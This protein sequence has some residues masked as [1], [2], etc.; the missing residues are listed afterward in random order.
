MK[1]KADRLRI[2][3]RPHFK[4]HQSLEVGRWHKEVGISKITVSSVDMALFF[5]ADWDDITIAFPVNLREKETI[6]VLCRRVRQLNLLVESAEVVH[7]LAKGLTGSVRLFVKIDTGYHRTGVAFQD[8]AM[9]RTILQAI[10]EYENV[11]FAG[12]LVHAGHTYDVTGKDAV[13]HI[14]T[15]AI[16]AL[17]LLNEK[18]RSVYPEMIISYGDTPSA[19]LM[20]DFGPVQELRPGNLAYY[21]V[22]Q[23]QIGACEWEQIAVCM[24]C[25]VVSIHPERNEIVVY[26]GGIHL[27]KD[28]IEMNARKVYGLP[29]YLNAKGW[30]APLEAGYVRKLSQEHG[31]IK[32]PSWDMKNFQPG[33]LV[34]ILP[35]HSCMA[36]D[37]IHDCFTLEGE[38]LDLF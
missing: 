34:G 20:E 12:F 24:A 23:M 14:H 5:S 28:F 13:K 38:R 16:R 4:T 10:S 17:H 6:N 29:V 7:K 1:A 21:D 27:S 8:D 9:I 30:S 3:Y 22:M 19:S 18:Y 25:P 32:L 31:V 35:V 2:T 36:V 37:C 11:S 26:G 15:E 33:S